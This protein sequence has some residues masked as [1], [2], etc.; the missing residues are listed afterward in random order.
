MTL[1]NWKGDVVALIAGAAMPLAFSPYGWWPLVFI[2]LF[3]FIHAISGVSIKRATMRGY[4]F[5]LGYF[6][7]GVSWV[8]VSI[9][10]F[11]NATTPLAVGIT[12][13]FI[14]I[15]SVYTALA[16]WLIRKLVSEKTYLSYLLV[17]PL[18]W[19]V[20][21]WVRGWLF[22]GFGWLQLGYAFVG[23]PLD[24]YASWIGVLGISFLAALTAASL[25][26]VFLKAVSISQRILAIV[27][28]V[29]VWGLPPLIDIPTF[30]QTHG[31]A[32]RVALMQA[33]IPQQIKW[34]KNQRQPTLDW[35]RENTEQHW[36]KDI[37]IWP[38]TAIPAFE[39]DVTSYFETMHAA[40]QLSDT[41]LMTGMPVRDADGKRYYNG[42]VALGNA[43]RDEESTY[44]KQHLVPFGEYLPFKFLLDPVLGF[45][46]IPMSNFSAGE[47]AQPLVNTGDYKAGVFICYEIAFGSDVIASLPE[48]DY[49]VNISNDA[50]FGGSLAPFQH[51]QITQMR[52]LETGRYI[53]RATN[54]GISAIIRPDGSLDDV[55][56]EGERGV[57]EGSIRPIR[58]ETV[59]A[60][61][62]DYPLIAFFLCSLIFLWSRRRNQ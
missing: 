50:W 49:L 62:G 61:I 11:G 12:L 53:L 27:L 3:A 23:T 45:L 22:T 46:E 20:V 41:T 42:L 43:N 29:L 47:Q 5:G 56:L 25:F 31:E 26:I 16:A 9:R 35:Y 7:V 28:I 59:Y 52:A 51:L 30:T 1:S 21:E 55:L 48:A 24:D 15:L 60:T 10:L 34:R 14:L 2:S 19:V 33:N 44:L 57:L 37:I 13:L 17:V 4:L 58:G 40:A 39:S 8:Y 6:G 38:E 54:T 36:N 18:V 32:Q